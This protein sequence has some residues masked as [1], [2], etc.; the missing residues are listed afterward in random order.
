MSASVFPVEN[1]PFGIISTSENVSN[2]FDVKS[3]INLLLIQPNPRPAA[4]IQ[5]TVLISLFWSGTTFSIQPPII[6]LLNV[7]PHQHLKGLAALP[8]R[9]QICSFKALQDAWKSGELQEKFGGALI[10]A[11]LVANHL[12]METRNYTYFVSSRGHFEN[13]S[14]TKLRFS[15]Y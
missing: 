9:S 1:V 10:P 11:S 15:Q 6:H 4:I 2:T 3:S 7:S 5:D 13:V 12:P 8:K 14:S